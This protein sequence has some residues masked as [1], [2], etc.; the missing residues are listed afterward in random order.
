MNLATGNIQPIK[1]LLI[2]MPKGGFTKRVGLGGNGLHLHGVPNIKE[3]KKIKR[4]ETAF[5]FN[6]LAKARPNLGVQFRPY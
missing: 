1:H 5:D 2:G 3:N 4:S 6:A